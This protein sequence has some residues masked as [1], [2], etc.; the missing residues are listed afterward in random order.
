MQHYSTQHL[1]AQQKL[2]FWNAIASATFAPLEF[3]PNDRYEFNGSLSRQSFG[4]FSFAEVNSA[5]GVIQLAQRHATNAVDRGYILLMPLQGSL[6][7]STAQST[8]ILAASDYCLLRH[9]LPYR[10]IQ[11]EASRIFCLRFSEAL[12]QRFMIDPS[13]YTGV[14]ISTATGMPQVSCALVQALRREWQQGTLDESATHLAPHVVALIAAA[15]RQ[16]ARTSIDTDRRR[17]R[18]CDYVEA[19]LQDSQL[20]PASIASH[21]GMSS[22]LVRLIFNRSDETL[23]GYILKRRLERCAECLRDPQ[24]RQLTLTDIAMRFGFNNS[25]QFGAAFK[26]RY[27]VTPRD[28]RAR[29]ELATH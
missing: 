25:T 2:S 21:F 27:G 7:V 29:A 10:L 4:E 8:A 1:P 9:S 17:Q 11:R 13:Q 12:L 26:K 23:S 5:P 6:E 3:T 14:R 20:T 28:Y 22:R 16:G 24:W 19:C 18:I 15:C